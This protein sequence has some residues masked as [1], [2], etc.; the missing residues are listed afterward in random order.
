MKI[1]GIIWIRDIVDKLALKHHVETHEIEEILSDKPKFRFVKKTKEVL[2]LSV[3]D[4]ARKEI[5]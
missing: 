5:I 4:I 1:E 2:I 3:R